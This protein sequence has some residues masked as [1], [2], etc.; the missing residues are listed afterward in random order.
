L[1]ERVKKLGVVGENKELKD[2]RGCF[3]WGERNTAA[4]R[5]NQLASA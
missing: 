3:S 1:N 4:F 2:Y 5:Y